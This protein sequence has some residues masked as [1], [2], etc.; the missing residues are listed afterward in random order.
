MTITG[1]SSSGAASC[2]RD[3]SSDD[4]G[5]PLKSSF[6]P[7]SPKSKTFSILFNFQ[8]NKMNKNLFNFLFCFIKREKIQRWSSK[9]SHCG[10]NHQNNSEKS[11]ETVIQFSIWGREI[12]TTTKAFLCFFL[13]AT[14]VLFV[15]NKA[16]LRFLFS[17]LAFLG[18]A[19]IFPFFFPRSL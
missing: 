8:L 3:T 17:F 4:E 18:N 15:L 2:C 13:S 5:H 16:K 19:R 6:S 11:E 1:V 10:R 7:H 12:N 14:Q 9:T